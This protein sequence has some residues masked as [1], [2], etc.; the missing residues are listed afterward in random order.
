M[1]PASLRY[2]A[3]SLLSGVYPLTYSNGLQN[4]WNT[5]LAASNSSAVTRSVAHWSNL[6][7]TGKDRS[8]ARY[9]PSAPRAWIGEESVPLMLAATAATRV[10]F[11]CHVW[12]TG[13][14]SEGGSG[15]ITSGAT[16]PPRITT[17]VLTREAEHD[18]R[19]WSECADGR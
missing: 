14:T 18:A 13:A 8:E 10:E 6:E 15:V 19:R 17:D 3:S 9:D 11:A 1:A 4:H 12:S 2:A 5:S 16:H 7:A